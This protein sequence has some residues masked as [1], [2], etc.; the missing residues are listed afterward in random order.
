MLSL[1]KKSPVED[2]MVLCFHAIEMKLGASH[3]II[4]VI[5]FFNTDLDTFVF[6][7]KCHWRMRRSGQM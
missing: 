4:R 1:L 2:K 7:R 5:D 3:W 6:Y